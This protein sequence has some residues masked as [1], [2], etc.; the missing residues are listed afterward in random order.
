M[1]KQLD[2]TLKIFE[3]IN[4]SD[5][6]IK[7]LPKS[8]FKEQYKNLNDLS[9]IFEEYSALL[10]SIKKDSLTKKSAIEEILVKIHL[11]LSGLIWHI[12]EIDELLKNLLKKIPE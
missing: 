9:D 12:E 4:K 6:V 8:C 10:L 1:I 3:K 7:K 2:E 5:F 11:K